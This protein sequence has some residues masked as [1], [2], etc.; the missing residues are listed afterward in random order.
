MYTCHLSVLRRSLVEEV[1]GFDPAVEGS[2]D[3][4]LILKV[5]ER[6]RAVA[7]IPRVLYH[8]RMLESSAAGGGEDAKPWAYDAGTR[9]LQA[10][11]ERI[12]L[13]ARVERD[14]DH[15][16]VYKLEPALDRRPP[17]SIIIPTAGQRRL[18][19]FEEIILATHCVRSIVETSTYD[20]Y[21]IVCVADTS[22]DLATLEELRAI[23]GDRLR[24]VPFNGPFSFSDK[25]NAGAIRSEGEHLLLLNDDMEVITPDWLERMVMYSSHPGIGAV[26]GHLI[27]ED[28]R[29]QHVGVLFENGG[30]PGHPYRGFPGDFTGYSNSVLVAQNLL[31]TTGACL[32]TPRAAFEEVGG[33]TT[34]L[35]VNYNDIDYCLKLRTLGLRIV[36]DPGT[37]LYHFESSSRSPDVEDWEIEALIERWGE[38]T[39]PDPYSNPSLR[40]GTPR[41]SSPLKWA[42]RRL[43]H[44]LTRRKART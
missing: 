23:A 39:D 7:H 6:A 19:R 11:C 26:G 13:P 29:L 42:V 33:M 4:D 24:T 30:F 17:V 22:T 31:A 16:G 37:R 15:P 3:W 10:H 36:Y 40:Y 21:E 35:P 32:M 9:A 20:N 14:L 41:L 34:T 28:G 5:S 25:V 18:V 27:W 43:P 2:Q 38:M 12:G 8:W 1:G 44:P